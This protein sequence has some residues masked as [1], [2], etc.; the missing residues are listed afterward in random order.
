MKN[1]QEKIKSRFELAEERIHEL[2]DRPVEIMKHEEQREKRMKKNKQSFREIWN[3]S[4]CNN[5]C[6][7]G[8]PKGKEKGRSRKTI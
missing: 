4:K 6:I 2:E 7:I 1:L 8:V 3:T 5:V